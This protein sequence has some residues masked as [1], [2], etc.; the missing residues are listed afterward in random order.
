MNQIN[1]P[2]CGNKCVKAG[3]TKAGTQRWLCKKCETSL[4][5]M[6]MNSL[7]LAVHWMAVPMPLQFITDSMLW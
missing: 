5:H 6:R 3:K 7:L 1:C 4:T 2:I